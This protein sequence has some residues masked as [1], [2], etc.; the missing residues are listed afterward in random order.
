M[1]NGGRGG[2]QG[3]A[4]GD[5]RAHR[6]VASVAP[7]FAV[8]AEELLDDVFGYLLYL[9]KNRA[10]AEDLTGETFETAFR[11]WRRF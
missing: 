4:R 5:P 2:V 3:H 6:P 1:T 9:T 11:K 10:V 7:S 8:V